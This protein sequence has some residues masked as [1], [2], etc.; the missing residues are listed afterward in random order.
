[1]FTSVEQQVFSD[2]KLNTSNRLAYTIIKQRDRQHGLHSTFEYVAEYMGVTVDRAKKCCNEL[3]N[4]GLIDIQ[5]RWHAP[6]ELRITE[7]TKNAQG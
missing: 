6:A 1:M 7:V 4:A 3:R 2:Y 5:Y